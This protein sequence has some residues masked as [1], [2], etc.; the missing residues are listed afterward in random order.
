V[1]WRPT[2]SEA[3]TDRSGVRCGDCGVTPRPA[4]Y[5][6]DGTE[7]FGLVCECGLS[8]AVADDAYDHPVPNT[9]TVFPPREGDGD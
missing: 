9:W 8:L 7:T 1:A 3:D 6:H 5:D 2:V 4:V